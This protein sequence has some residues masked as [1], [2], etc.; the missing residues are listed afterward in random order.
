MDSKRQRTAVISN[1]P[2]FARLTPGECQT[3]AEI[4]KERTLDDGQKLCRQGEVE[5]FMA[6]VVTGSL[7]VEIDAKDGIKTVVSRRQRCQ[8]IGEMACLDPSPRSATVCAEGET[9]VLLLTR[10]MLDVL[11]ENAPGVFS[12]VVRGIGVRL[13]ENLDKTNELIA[14]L[15]QIG[16]VP[17]QMRQ[18]SDKTLQA[19][20]TR[21]RVINAVERGIELK[22]GGALSVLSEQE[23]EVL[24]A[25]TEGRRFAAGEVIC[26]EGEPAPEAYFVAEGYVEVLKNVDGRNWRLATI[27]DNGV[28]GQRALL[29]EGRRSA[30]VRAGS[31][32]TTLFALSRDRFDS[33][34]EARSALAIGFQ[35]AVTI[36]GI[37]QLRQANEMAAYLGAREKRLELPGPTS[38]VLDGD[39]EP[40]ES[41]EERIERMIDPEVEEREIASLASAYLETAMED[42]ELTP[43]KLDDIEV[44]KSSE[45]EA[46][47]QRTEA[48]SEEH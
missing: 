30:T 5:D 4:F 44:V 20:M 8:A 33:L 19:G 9:K 46:V 37:Q 29:R 36:A 39:T 24:R 10:Y 15:L 31:E 42:W 34:L 17:E 22:P 13:A 28:L 40:D 14:E 35:Q 48:E 45:L 38:D 47:E 21:G 27:D 1:T 32:G 18:P 23:C 26:M 25:A 3:L 12:K 41:I 16:D 7:A 43:S 2:I 6:V 11:R